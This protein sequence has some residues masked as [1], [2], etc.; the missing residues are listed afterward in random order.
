MQARG[1]K[2]QRKKERGRNKYVSSGLAW[3]VYVVPRNLFCFTC[4]SQNAESAAVH[5]HGTLRLE[6]TLPHALGPLILVHSRTNS[7]NS[8]PLEGLEFIKDIKGSSREKEGGG[9]ERE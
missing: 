7:D 3:H 1:K 5:Y 6:A 9:R 2:K 8:R 4:F